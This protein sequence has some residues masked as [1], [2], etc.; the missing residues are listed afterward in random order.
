MEGRQ[1]VQQL[2]QDIHF[3]LQQM[4]GPA[5]SN[6][7]GD[8]QLQTTAQGL[9]SATNANFRDRQPTPQVPK[10]QHFV[11]DYEIHIES[12]VC[13]NFKFTPLFIF[14]IFYCNT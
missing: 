8:F 10:G 14:F 12:T 3:I 4:S 6:D 9:V 7:D 5:S 11:F 13:I 2:G 1:Q